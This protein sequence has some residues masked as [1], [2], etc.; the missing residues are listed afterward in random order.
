MTARQR[1]PLE[2]EYLYEADSG[3]LM[4]YY[5][6]G[7]HDPFTFLAEL[8]EEGI[9]RDHLCPL[10]RWDDEAGRAAWR[11]ALTTDVRHVYWRIVP[12]GDDE[13]IFHESAGPGRGAFPATLIDAKER[14]W[15]RKCRQDFKDW[16]RP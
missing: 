3:P 15:S 12:S 13:F 7:H 1:H 8:V 6:K 5:S 16:R 11:F 9:E 4:G 10:P 2:V 14:H